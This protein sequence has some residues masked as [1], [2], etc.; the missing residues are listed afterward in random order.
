VGII[1]RIG[2]MFGGK[3]NDRGRSPIEIVQRQFRRTAADATLL[4]KETLRAASIGPDRWTA[5]RT[6]LASSA[7]AFFIYAWWNHRMN[8]EDPVF[9]EALNKALLTMVDDIIEQEGGD[10]EEIVDVIRT[11]FHEIRAAFGRMNAGD[12]HSGEAFSLRVQQILLWISL[13]D[14]SE[15]DRALDAHSAQQLSTLMS[16]TFARLGSPAYP[17]EAL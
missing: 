6:A 4:L 11:A 17:S 12:V 5:G 1:E 7:Y 16:A 10:Q 14:A 3:A 2:R 8:G 9:L 15:I 13:T